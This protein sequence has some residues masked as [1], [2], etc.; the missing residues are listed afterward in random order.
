[1]PIPTPHAPASKLSR[2]GGEVWVD[3][4]NNPLQ[5]VEILEDEQGD[6]GTVSAGLFRF[7]KTYTA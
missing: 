3:H 7:W 1:M 2:G 6:T 4:P 5:M